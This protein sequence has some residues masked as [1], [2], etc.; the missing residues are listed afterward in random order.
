MLK[1]ASPVLKIFM[2]VLLFSMF[3]FAMWKIY[4]LYQIDKSG[5]KVTATIE[6]FEEKKSNPQ[7]L[8]NDKMAFAPIFSFT[9]ENGKK[10]TLNSGNFTEE[11]KYQIGDEVTAVYAK[12]KPLTAVLEGNF[13]WKFYGILASLGF[14]GSILLVY[15]LMNPPR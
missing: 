8:T 10:F 1:D 9:A 15:Y 6:G 5:V 11:K 7:S 14:V 12:D 2:L 4:Q 3:V 13:P